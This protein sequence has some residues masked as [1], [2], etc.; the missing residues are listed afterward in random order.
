M[1]LKESTKNIKTVSQYISGT[2]N[3]EVLAERGNQILNCTDSI[4]NAKVYTVI[5]CVC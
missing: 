1:I 2:E 3:K 5:L 4:K